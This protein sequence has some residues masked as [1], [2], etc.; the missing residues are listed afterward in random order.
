MRPM[1]PPHPE[2]IATLI[3]QP[4]SLVVLRCCRSRLIDDEGVVCAI[5]GGNVDLHEVPGTVYGLEAVDCVP[6]VVAGAP[7]E[8][9]REGGEEVIEG[10]G[11]DDVVVEVDKKGNEHDTPSN[12][13]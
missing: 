7:G 13:C 12:A 10:P 8:D 5:L 3:L 9:S 1:F 11:D 2:L 4:D 6:V